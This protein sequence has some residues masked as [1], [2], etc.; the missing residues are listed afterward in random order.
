[1][2]KKDNPDENKKKS[3]ISKSDS[4]IL[5]IGMMFLA[6]ILI[7]WVAGHYAD[8]IFDTGRKYTNIGIFFGMFCGFYNFV[9]IIVEAI[10][11]NTKK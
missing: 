8:K 11:D 1:M 2:L 9:K 3:I 6:C 10:R 4:N 5:N 7:C